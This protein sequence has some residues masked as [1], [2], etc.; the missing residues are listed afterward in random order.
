MAELQRLRRGAHASYGF[1]RNSSE[2]GPIGRPS[3]PRHAAMN[4][5]EQGSIVAINVPIAGAAD[6]ARREGHDERKVR[7]QWRN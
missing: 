2:P 3:R 6:G 4:A 1:G 7:Q 5:I